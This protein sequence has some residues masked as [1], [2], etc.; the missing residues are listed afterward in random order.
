MNDIS[1]TFSHMQLVE[2]GTPPVNARDRLIELIQHVNDDQ[3]VQA[4]KFELKRVLTDHERLV[5]MLQQRSEILEQQNDDLKTVL[6]EQQRRY[7]KA[8][9]EMQFFRRKYDQV[10]KLQN[11]GRKRSDSNGSETSADSGAKSVQRL[12]SYPLTPTSTE[13]SSISVVDS[14]Y[15]SYDTHNTHSDFGKPKSFSCR[16]SSA[17]P[18]NTTTTN[19]WPPPSPMSH[20]SDTTASIPRQRQNSSATASVYSTITTST[21]QSGYSQSSKKSNPQ[22]SSWQ[23]LRNPAMALSYSSPSASPAPPMCG[24][25]VSSGG[26]VYSVPMNPVRS[27]TATNGYTGSSLIQQRRTDPLIFG[28]SDGLWDTIAKSKG[29]D[30]T[31]EKITSNFLRRGGSPNTAKQSPSTNAVKYGYG[32][33]HALIVTK[34]PGSLDLLLQQGANPNAVTLSQVEEDRVTPCYLAASVGWLSGLQ[35]LVQAGGDLIAARGGGAKSKTALHVA[36][37]HCHAA[38]IEYIV[39]V[40]Q[41]AL[42]LETDSQGAT[43]MH[44]ACASGHTDLVSL[45]AR[46]CQIPVNQA[47]HKE[48]LPLHWAAKHGRLEVVTLLIERF[49]CDCN[50]Y[51]SRKVGT[52]LDFAKSNGHKRLVDYLKGIG[53]LTAKKMDK[54]MEE[55]LSKQVP[56]HLESTLLKN[57]LFGDDNSFF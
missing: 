32:M 18:N 23:F 25:S 14:L 15:S 16:S 35:K 21:D 46:S 42:N 27:A 40:T 31:V 26:S 39:N 50:A 20:T 9:R 22:K 8:V 3:I 6:A 12:Q 11:P 45:L 38:V 41:G 10:A 49:N 51:V 53:A 54:K 24:S 48:E 4:M 33:I 36:A 57:G 7:E 44:Y 19:Y 37:E 34:A 56:R 52:P 30:V 1:H 5:T 17:G 29:S 13:P 2:K 28:G 43:V 47:D 55:E